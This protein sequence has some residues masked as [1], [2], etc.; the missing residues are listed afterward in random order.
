MLP[1]HNTSFKRDVLL[2]Y[3][4]ELPDLLRAEIVLH[5]RLHRDGHRLLLE[6]AAKFEHINESTLASASE[7]PL[8]SSRGS[9]AARANSHNRTRS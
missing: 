9:A 5:T 6:P 4:D 8:H 3:G 7:F 1:G 2:A